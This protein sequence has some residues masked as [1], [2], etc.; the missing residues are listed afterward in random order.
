M[1]LNNH[2]LYYIYDPMCSWC[3]AFERSLSE[4]K[5]QLPP[6]I[7][8]QGVLG[9]LAADSQQEMPDDTKIM[10]QNAWRNIEQSVPHIQFNYDFWT[11]NTP[12]RATYPACRALLA[13]EQQGKLYAE[14]LRLQ[15]QQAYYQDAKNPS[16]DAILLACAEQVGLNVQQFSSDFFSDEIEEKLQQQIQF[17]RALG[18]N[19]YPSLRLVLNEEIH[20]IPLNYTQSKPSLQQITA[21]ISQHKRRPTRSPCIKNCCLNEQDLCM[22]CF[23][24]LEEITQWAYLSEPEKKACLELCKQREV[25]FK[26]SP[27]NKI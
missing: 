25:T 13:A 16:L 17:S 9:G 10:V 1:Q 4:I 26:N 11:N 21:L 19:S 22:G 23:R 14:A 20:T 18:V 3:Y 24:L 15:I 12:I 2:T 6:L 27:N 5:Q 8:F 7:T